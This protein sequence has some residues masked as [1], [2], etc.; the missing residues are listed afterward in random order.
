MHRSYL[1][2]RAEP[3][4]MALEGFQIVLVDHLMRLSRDQPMSHTAQ[5]M[6]QLG[7]LYLDAVGHD[8]SQRGHEATADVPDDEIGGR[9]LRL[10]IG[11]EEV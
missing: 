6:Q 1:I 11:H 3:R 7:G 5:Q 4:A 10:E 8:Q 2:I 9:M